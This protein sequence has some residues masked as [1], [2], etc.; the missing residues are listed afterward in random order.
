MIECVSK[1]IYFFDIIL[2]DV[3]FYQK[4]KRSLEPNQPWYGMQKRQKNGMLGSSMND[5]GTFRIEHLE[6]KV[7]NDN[8]WCRPTGR[9]DI[10][11]TEEIQ[12]LPIKLKLLM[13]GIFQRISL[14]SYLTMLR[15]YKT[16][17]TMFASYSIFNICTTNCYYI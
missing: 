2:H 9:D 10:Q 12:I 15:T 17:L 11:D 7:G 4:L 5:D 8:S 3:G 14:Y 16:V 6:R 13:N 1:T